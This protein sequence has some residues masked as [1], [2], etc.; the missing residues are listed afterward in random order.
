VAFDERGAVAPDAGLGVGFYN[1]GSISVK[2]E[3]ETGCLGFSRERDCTHLVFHRACAFLTFSRAVCSVN[4]R[5][6]MFDSALVFGYLMR[7]L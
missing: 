7:M 5:V 4:A 1:F 3:L 6:D 2:D